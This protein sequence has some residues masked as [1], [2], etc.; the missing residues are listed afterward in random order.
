MHARADVSEGTTPV[1]GFVAWSGTGKTTLLRNLIP[2]LRD[3]GLRVGVV[4]H[5]HHT[6]DMD[7][8]G[9][10]SYE[11]RK[12]GAQ[13]VLVG[14]RTRF[15]LLVEQSLRDEPDLAD[16]LSHMQGDD[17]DLILVEGFKHERFPK[18]EL[19][20]SALERPLLY[21]QD[22]AIIA[23]ATDAP[24][25]PAPPLPVLDLNDVPRVAAFVRDFTRAARP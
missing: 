13:R 22:D 25:S 16:L 15:V 21:P 9:K 17:L 7:Q 3:Q 10:D 8:P 24:L 2:L 12:A 19:H 5:A 11:L 23:V 4:K 1:L 6:F 18:V 14:S 20:R